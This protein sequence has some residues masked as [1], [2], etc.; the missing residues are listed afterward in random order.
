MTSLYMKNFEI[1]KNPEPILLQQKS[2]LT[3]NAFIPDAQKE[4]ELQ[5]LQNNANKIMLE[6]YNKNT[7]SSIQNLSLSEINKNMANSVIGLMDDLLNKPNN[8]GWLS[9]I[10]I[11]L[12]KD[13]RYTYIGIIFVIIAVYIIL[14]TNE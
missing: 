2:K 13:N 3:T 14:T 8:V 4:N 1:I 6:Y 12:K 10:E 11:C 7:T 9:H 5:D